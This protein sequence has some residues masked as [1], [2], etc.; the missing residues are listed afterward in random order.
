[1]VRYM[2]DV[3]QALAV[4]HSLSLSEED[5]NDQLYL[6]MMTGVPTTSFIYFVFQWLSLEAVGLFFKEGK[7]RKNN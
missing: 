6:C 7:R 3:R 2:L 4:L 1:M 5:L